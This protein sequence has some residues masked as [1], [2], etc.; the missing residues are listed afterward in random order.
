MTRIH[1]IEAQFPA[2]PS[3]EAAGFLFECA[4]DT[5]FHA[6][7]RESFGLPELLGDFEVLKKGAHDLACRLLDGEP[8]FRGIQQLGIFRENVIA[9]IQSALALQKLDIA[10]KGKGFSTARFTPGSQLAAGFAR[11][12]AH[13][14]EGQRLAVEETAISQ[15]S[16]TLTKGMRRLRE[17]RFSAQALRDEAL[18]LADRLDPYRRWRPAAGS[19]GKWSPGEIWFYTT[20][21]TFTMAGLLYEPYFPESF[22]FLVENRR[23]GGRALTARSRPFVDLYAFA[24]PSMAPRSDEIG[25]AQ[26][27]IE[28]H[29]RALP[30]SGAE[31]IARDQ[32]LDSPFMARFLARHLPEGLFAAS[33]FQE[34]IE[35]ARPKALV[36]G[37][38]VFEGYAMQAAQRQGIP[39]ITL[40]HGLFIDYCQYIVPAA[41]AFIVRGQFWRDFLAPEAA[42]KALVLNPPEPAK[43]AASVPLQ[44]RKALVFLTAPYV[45]PFWSDAEI[46]EILRVVLTCAEKTGAELIMRIHPM[47][48]VAAYEERIRRLGPGQHVKIAFSQGAGLDD[49]LSRARLAVTYFST[50]FQDCLRHQVPMVSLGWHDFAP[51]KLMERHG[52]FHFADSLEELESL[53]TKGLRERLPP[54]SSIEPFLATSDPREIKDA[55]AKALERPARVPF[56]RAAQ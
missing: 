14:P 52:I 4:P 49:L 51:K 48:S 33:L 44:D 55:I 7:F 35:R 12:Q 13:F 5:K 11:L 25:T 50:V 39:S 54:S 16:Q 2:I 17:A 47:D 41:D 31:A 18:A 43:A 37:N 45:L 3:G 40:Q 56:Q 38:Y 36:T 19:A 28:A 22:R 15:L 26:R 8:R 46:Q 10:L 34:W 1:L 24:R 32:F 23:T 53:V 20:A 30:L 21:Y 42:A 9:E 6:R 29:L 27:A